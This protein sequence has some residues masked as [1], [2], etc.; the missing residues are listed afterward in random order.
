SYSKLMPGQSF[1]SFNMRQFS[2]GLSNES[3]GWGPGQFNSLIF[4]NNASGFGHITFRT[5]NPVD[6]FVGKI[7]FEVLGGSLKSADFQPNYGTYG[8][9]NKPKNDRYVSG[10]N[11]VFSPRWFNGLHFGFSRIFQVY[12]D[13]LG[14][15]LDDYLPFF[16]GFQK[17]VVGFQEDAKNR[18]QQVS[19]SARWVFSK[20]NAEIYFEFGK[21]DHALNWRDFIMSPS[22]ARAF[23]FGFQKIFAFNASN[24]LQLRFEATQ[25]QQAIN[26][27]IRDV[28]QGAGQS[29]GGHYPVTQGFS[30]YGQQLGNGVGPGNNVQ[31]LE[32]SWVRDV[33]K[34][35][36]MFERLE[37][38]MDFFDRAFL[39]QSPARPWV[40]I[41]AGLV[42]NWRF[43]RLVANARVQFIRSLNYQ[44]QQDFVYPGSQNAR[45]VDRFNLHSYM[46]VT[47][48]F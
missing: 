39:D 15:K 12:Y 27:L 28:N 41:S 29:W 46:G 22:H 31:T 16:D 36:V 30:H 9:I 34:L 33:R 3:P 18:S 20:A 17:Q 32:I 21:R 37:H 23:L 7:E 1:I 13:D 35:G 48:L 24:S 19:V 26:R 42:G 4:S 40:D 44:W 25:S 45:G 14:T 11:F 2:L 5:T 8:P 6:I 47:Y 38:Q 43:N 10:L